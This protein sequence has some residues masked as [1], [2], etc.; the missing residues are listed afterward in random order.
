M[1]RLHSIWK[2]FIEERSLLST[3]RSPFQLHSPL[4]ETSQG[5][6]HTAAQAQDE[7]AMGERAR[8]QEPARPA[9]CQGSRHCPAGGLEQTTNSTAPQLSHLENG[10]QRL[11]VDSGTTFIYALQ[12]LIIILQMVTWNALL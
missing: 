7:S 10:I 1:V 5:D 8:G 12:L 6:L 2:G 9:R 3:T 4:S 11:Y